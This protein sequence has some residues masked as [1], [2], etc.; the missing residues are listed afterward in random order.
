MSS[1]LAM[2]SDITTYAIIIGLYYIFMP[3]YKYVHNL[4]AI[5]FPIII[6]NCHIFVDL[7]KVTVLQKKFFYLY[8]VRF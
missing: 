1:Q 6:D 8:F 3:L 2:V 7:C 4:F 5:L